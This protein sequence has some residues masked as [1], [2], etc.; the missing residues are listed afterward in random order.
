MKILAPIAWSVLILGQAGAL[1]GCVGS[2]HAWQEE[3]FEDFGVLES[4]DPGSVAEVPEPEEAPGYLEVRVQEFMEALSLRVLMGPG[5]G[6]RAAV[7]KLLQA[8]IMYRGPS[9]SQGEILYFKTLVFGNTGREYGV[10]DLR[11]SEYGLLAWY[12]YHEDVAAWAG[13]SGEWRGSYEA[14]S[15]TALELSAHG[16]VAH[17]RPRDPGRSGRSG[18]RVASR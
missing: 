15:P 11:S 13:G 17:P 10:W 2:S 5:I 1:V 18:R 7:T 6:V 3:M 16:Q 4:E 9:E 12:N 8:G 14:R